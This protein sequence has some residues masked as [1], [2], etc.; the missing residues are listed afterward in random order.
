M[1]GEIS[2]LGAALCWAVSSTF[3]KSLA[4]RIL[5]MNLNLLRCLAGSAFFFIAIPFSGGLEALT[6]VPAGAVVYLVASALVGMVVGDTIYFIGLRRVNVTI[7]LPLSQSAMPL[8]TLGFAVLFLGEAVT[9]SLLLG[10][11]LV[12]IGNYLVIS[13]PRNAA[14]V[15]KEE[16]A[17]K[18]AGLFMI[19]AAAGLW[20][21]SIALLKVG[22][23]GA[24]PVVANTLR[25]PAAT[26]AILFFVLLPRGSRP[27]VSTTPR[28]FLLGLAT[29]VISFGIGGILFLLSIQHA[30]AG[31]AAVLTSCAP[32]FGLPFSV[33]YLKERADRKCV[34][35]TALLVLGVVFL[36]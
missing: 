5:P 23:S 1:I 18:G 3:S 12:L 31:K 26:V 15:G 34:I 27:A 6:R 22:L 35:G 21:V 19:V 14:I 16:G 24:S 33:L 9:R 32:L 29:G 17:G 2:G 7:A 10:T 11:A 36:V 28:D 20:A 25:L 4:G 30:G 13:P 8:I